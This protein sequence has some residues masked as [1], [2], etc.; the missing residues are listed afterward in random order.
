MTLKG[1]AGVSPRPCRERAELVALSWALAL[2]GAAA[3]SSPP[4][5]G[6]EDRGALPVAGAGLVSWTYF[7][8]VSTLNTLKKDFGLYCL[9]CYCD[10]N[11]LFCAGALARRSGRDN[12]LSSPGLNVGLDQNL[13]PGR[14]LQP[15]WTLACICR[16]SGGAGHLSGV[17]NENRF[18]FFARMP[19]VLEFGYLACCCI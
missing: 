12:L 6:L 15:L 5:T 9:Y 11:L 10:S 13:R 2:A 8:Q 16:F 3:M 14:G 18:L 17:E 19:R 1:G 7:A 4:A